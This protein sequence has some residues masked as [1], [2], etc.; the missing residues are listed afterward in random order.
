MRILQN[1]FLNFQLT[2]TISPPNPQEQMDYIAVSKMVLKKLND[3]LPNYL[4]Y[5][6]VAHTTDVIDAA[7]EI[8]NT[9]GIQG[10]DLTLLKTAALFHDTGYIFGAKDHEK[11]SCEL[12]DKY[13]PEYG[14]SKDQINKIK[15]IIMATR[16]P[17][18]PKDHLGEILADA[19]LDY[20]GRDDYFTIN[21]KLFQELY[22]T[23]Q[24]LNEKEWNKM[25]QEFFERHSYFTN[26]SKVK[27]NNSKMNNLQSIHA[28]TL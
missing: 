19:D 14:Y 17:Q 24:V 23:G 4:T 28:S 1:N 12:A 7:I 25:Q 27:R 15:E 13:L 16:I 9:E 26:T 8:S 21:K 10:D 20:L 22:S 11:K 2:Y 18:T 3:E 6:C 5:H